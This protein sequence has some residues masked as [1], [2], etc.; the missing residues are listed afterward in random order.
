[1][2]F[3]LTKHRGQRNSPKPSKIHA[4]VGRHSHIV[5]LS[6]ATNAKKHR[7]ASHPRMCVCVPFYH[8]SPFAIFILQHILMCK[9]Q[10]VQKTEQDMRKTACLNPAFQSHGI[11]APSLAPQLCSSG[12]PRPPAAP[13][14]REHQLGQPEQRPALQS[15]RRQGCGRRSRAYT[16][17][18]SLESAHLIGPVTEYYESSSPLPWATCRA[19]RSCHALSR[20]SCSQTSS[21]ACMAR[22]LV[23]WACCPPLP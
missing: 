5:A 9:Q 6:I 17:S 19:V 18:G 22:H 16:Q 15:C 20:L 11:C 12:I 21:P 2:H 3:S 23:P 14:R 10:S 13:N 1:M 4:L 8:I 7:Q